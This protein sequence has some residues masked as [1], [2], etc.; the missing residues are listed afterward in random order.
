MFWESVARG[1]GVLLWWQT[2][3]AGLEYLVILVVPSLLLGRAT[4]KLHGPVDL[5]NKL[6]ALVLQVTAIAVLVLTLSPLIFG[7]GQYAMWSLPWTVSSVIPGELSR[8][9]GTLGLIA[10]GLMTF[11]VLGQLQSLH[12]L[13]LGST[14]VLFAIGIMRAVARPRHRRAHHSGSGIHRRTGGDLLARVLGR[15]HGESGH[16]PIIIA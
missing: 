5:L 11:P 4:A 15:S 1:L 8:L 3:V 13:L 14:A 9:I 10:I 12:T 2:W 7:F 6:A 16:R